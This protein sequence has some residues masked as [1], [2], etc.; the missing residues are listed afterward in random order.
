MLLSLTKDD[1]KKLLQR[2]KEILNHNGVGF[3]SFWKGNKIENIEGLL[4][5]YYETEDMVGDISYLLVFLLTRVKTDNIG[6]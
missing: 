4:F 3:H 2:Q 5:T 6:L 1:L